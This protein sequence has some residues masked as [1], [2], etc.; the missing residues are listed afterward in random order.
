MKKLLIVLMLILLLACDEEPT[1]V[2]PY[3]SGNCP[4]PPPNYPDK[5]GNVVKRGS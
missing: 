2:P 4:V 3:A 5:N 1:Q